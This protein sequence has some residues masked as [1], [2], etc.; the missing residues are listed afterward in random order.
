MNRRNALKAT[1]AS[2]LAGTALTTSATADTSDGPRI[3][4]VDSTT[5][6]GNA[7][8]TDEYTVEHLGD[9]VV[10]ITRLHGRPDAVPR[11]RCRRHP[12]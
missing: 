1:G 9:G 7:D 11:G 5:D 6:S 10:E 8:G 3:V 4:S 12:S 2:L